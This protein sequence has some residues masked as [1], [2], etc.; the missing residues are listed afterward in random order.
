M[1]ISFEE[2]CQKYI[3]VQEVIVTGVED[4]RSVEHDGLL[5]SVASKS[6]LLFTV[7]CCVHETAL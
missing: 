2:C 5:P 3:A 4:V 6:N 1:L 7:L